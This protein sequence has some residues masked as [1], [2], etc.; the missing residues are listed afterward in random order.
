MHR[1]QPFL[2]RN[3][4]SPSLHTAVESKPSRRRSSRKFRVDMLRLAI[5]SARAA[6][7]QLARA[8]AATASRAPALVGAVAATIGATTMGVA[9]C[10]RSANPVTPYTGVAGTKFERSFIAIKPDG[11]QRGLISDIIGRFE[12]KGFKLVALKMIWPSEERAREHYA[13]LAKR[14]FF[15]GLVD[16]FSSGPVVA[17]VW[18][19]TG[20]IKTG[21]WLLGETNPVASTPGSIRGDFCVEM[22]RNICHGSD[23]PESAAHE[24]GMWFT[25][26]ELSSWP[27]ATDV[28]TYEK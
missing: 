11:V 21:R 19:G 3:N 9:S 7:P 18:E 12:K 14:P 1:L 20:V 23:G 6:A 4:Y 10:D 24:I 16:F 15:P 26:E 5:R 17:M 8:A 27:R 28:W 2:H 22:G 25:E 13:D